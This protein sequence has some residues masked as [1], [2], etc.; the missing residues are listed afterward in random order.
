VR[1]IFPANNGGLFIDGRGSTK[2][3]LWRPGHRAC[4]LWEG[5]GLAL[6]QSG[7][8]QRCCGDVGDVMARQGDE[9]ERERGAVAS[10]GGSGL[11]SSLL[12]SLKAG[13]WAGET[14]G[15]QRECPRHGYRVQA[16]E[17]SGAHS[18]TDFLRFLLTTCS[19]KCS[20][21]FEFQIF[22]NGHRGSSTYWTRVLELFL[23]QRKMK[24]CRN[25]ISNFGYCHYFRFNLWLMFELSYT[26]NFGLK[27]LG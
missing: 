20:Q 8:V 6:A 4:R 18:E 19:I 11:L 24:F 26:L 23:F 10:G 16:R 2:D 17:N 7:H 5:Q 25:H 22:E 3:G 12:P 9:G 15:R 21:E 1:R 14:G 27:L 13:V